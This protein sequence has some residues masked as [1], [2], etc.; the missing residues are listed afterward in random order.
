MNSTNNAFIFSLEGNIGV[1]KSTIIN[2]LKLNKFKF[3]KKFVYLEEPVNMWEDVKDENGINILEN[4]YKNTKEYAFKFQM[5]VY[6]SRLSLLRK[7]IKENPNSIILIE[8]SI[9]AD[10]NIFVKMLYDN[11]KIDK[12]EYEIYNKLFNE[13]LDD[14]NISGIIYLQCNA[15]ICLKRIKERNRLG[16]NVSIQYLENC[17]KY[18]KD[19]INNLKIPVSVLNC[20]IDIKNN[21]HIVSTWISNIFEF[22][23]KSVNKELKTNNYHSRSS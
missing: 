22:I 9:Y 12:I 21:P 16:E 14:V 20:N 10:K 5:L 2:L 7:T 6:I 4:Y 15:D 13:F 23:E 8:R 3:N 1:G 19:W 11:N 18:H 17:D